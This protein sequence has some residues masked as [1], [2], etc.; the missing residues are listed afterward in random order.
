MTR[1]LPLLL[2][3]T[4]LV[5]CLV[6]CFRTPE[7]R[8]KNLPKVIWV[9][10]I[11]IIPVVGGVVWL[12]AGKARGP[13]GTRGPSRGGGGFGR[14]PAGPSKGPDDDEDFLRGLK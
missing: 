12:V 8:V 13:R 5:Y 7:E 1:T 2:L 9:L 4:F 3:I 11:L 6:D 10:I 14:G